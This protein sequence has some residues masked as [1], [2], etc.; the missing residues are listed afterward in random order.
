MKPSMIFYPWK[1]IRKETIEMVDLFKEE[2]LDYCPFKGSWSVGQ[3]FLHISESE[4]W[5][6]HALV[7]KDLPLD[8]KYEFKDFPSNRALKSKLAISHERTLKFLESIQEPDLDW[9]FKTPEGESL[10]LYQILWHVLEHEIHHR[11]ELSLILGMLGRSGA[12]V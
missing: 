6:I 11:G 5:W 2:E 1:A 12:D 7:R 9:R 8:L 3:I 10:A 4:D